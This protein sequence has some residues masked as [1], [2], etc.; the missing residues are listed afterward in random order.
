MMMSVLDDPV[1]QRLLASN[2]YARIAYVAFDGTPRLNP[3]VFVR[4]GSQI[5]LPCFASAAKLRANPAITTDSAGQSPEVL[6]L[7]GRAG[8]SM[9][10]IQLRPSWIGV[11]DFQTRLPQAMAEAFA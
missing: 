7:R 8:V 10:R 9:A 6:Q 11:L 1:V 4:N 3:M 5:V 2:S